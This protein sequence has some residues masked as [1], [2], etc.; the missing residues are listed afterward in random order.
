M[1]SSNALVKKSRTSEAISL[2]SEAA[3]MSSRV[4]ATAP[5]AK[6][7]Q[8]TLPSMSN[9]KTLEVRDGDMGAKERMQTG[10]CRNRNGRSTRLDGPGSEEND[11]F[12]WFAPLL[13]ACF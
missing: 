7:P 4:N 3:R 2:R 12:R 5:G 13:F 9:A 10:P 11:D 8:I 1:A 6:T